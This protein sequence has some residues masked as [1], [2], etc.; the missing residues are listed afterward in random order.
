MNKLLHYG[1][2]LIFIL[3]GIA[4]Y[5]QQPTIEWAQRFNSIDTVSS[6]DKAV[7]IATDAQGNVYITGNS[8]GREPERIITLK[9]SPA[10]Q[11]IWSATYQAD[12]A[13]LAHDIAIDNLGGVYVLGATSG[14][15][16]DF[17]TIRYDALTGQRSWVQQF[18]GTS[19]RNDQPVAIATD[20]S[21]GV[22]VTGTSESNETE[23]NIATIRYDALTGDETWVSQYSGPGYGS[24]GAG[25]ATDNNGNVY[26]IGTS[27]NADG[28]SR[29]MVT[30][31]YEVATGSEKWAIRYSNK[32]RENGDLAYGR[33]IA[34]D[35]NGIV[36]ITGSSYGTDAG[37]NYVTISYDAAG[38]ERWLSR[39]NY[40]P[41]VYSTDEVSAITVDN[42]G[43]VYVTGTSGQNMTTV[44]YDA[45][46]GSEK[47]AMPYENPNSFSS[48]A[49]AITAD[50]MGGVY[51][52]GTSS[53]DIITVRYNSF[54]GKLEWEQIF[55][56]SQQPNSDEAVD[57]A[58]DN[59]GKLYVTSNTVE[60][61]G[62]DKSDIVTIAY[63]A[64]TGQPLWTQTYDRLSS[65]PTNDRPVAVAIDA[66]GNSYVTGTS[67]GEQTSSLVIIKY[68]PAG[69]SLW[70]MEYSSG[71]TVATAVAVDNQGS[72]YVSG[73]RTID[74]W[75][76][77]PD[78][79]TIR[80]NAETGQEVWSSRYRIEEEDY[81]DDR[82]AGLALDKAGN[83]YV[84]GTT[85]AD[86]VVIR[87]EA[88][89]GDTLWVSRFDAG[90]EG[91]NE[92]KAVAI[93]TDP[94]GAVYVT[95][96]TTNYS[97]D[98]GP[99]FI[100][101][102]F[103]ASDG[104]QTWASRYD[105][106]EGYRQEEAVDITADGQGGVYITGMSNGDYLTIRYDATTG[107][108]SWAERYSV[109][110]IGY[111]QPRA[112]AADGKGGVFVTGFG[113]NSSTFYDFATVR[114]DAAT[115]KL[116]WAQTYNYTGGNGDLATA[117]TVDS[118]GGVYVTGY[119]QVD[120][121]GSVYSTV[122]YNGSSGDQV[123]AV[124]TEGPFDSPTDLAIDPQG[125]VIVT[126][127]SMT[128]SADF[129]TIK[130]SQPSVCPELPEVSIT[131]P[132]VARAGTSGSIYTLSATGAT[133]F[134]WQITDSEGRDFTAFSG[135]GTE[136]ISVNWTKKPDVYKVTVSYG[137]TSNCP[138]LTAIRYVHVSDPV[139]GYV[140]GG[141][142]SHAAANPAY[143]FMHRDSRAYWGFVAKY[144]QAGRLQ[145]QTHLILES[146]N[147]YFR[148]T[149]LEDGSLVIMDNRAYVRGY[150][151]LTRLSTTGN[152]ENDPRRFGFLIAA[153]DVQ[154]GAT[155]VSWN[156][157]EKDRLR[158]LIWEINAD[159]TRGTVVY[160]NQATC[161]A[162]LDEHLQA[163]QSIAGGNIIIHGSQLM[164]EQD[165]ALLAAETDQQLIA[166]PTAFQQQ[167]T[168]AFTP[169]QQTAYSLDLYDLKGGLVRQIA[170]GDAENGRRY[171]HE[172]QATGLPKGLYFVRLT[173]DQGVN[174]VKIVV[175]H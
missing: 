132:G 158:I 18:N 43:G 59:Q 86:I 171:E 35:S 41:G 122:K 165:N 32:D 142:W 162:N 94:E 25:I 16:S 123:W 149:S 13:V 85:G 34:I 102:R 27:S 23:A 19:N 45:L 92:E 29:D 11:L 69:D 5:A 62:D 47:W 12:E 112:I 71:Y 95:G 61:G 1:L 46:T 107:E 56:S 137:T 96:N 113:Y 157:R 73:T 150:G 49:K 155:F 136:T 3:C 135:Q 129:L 84:A 167:T 120:Q 31:R 117:I 75:G 8:H 17:I 114:Y 124:Q 175:Q 68:S 30:I 134:L 110:E 80:Y 130:Y 116:D 98:S 90:L 67:E 55:N 53:E 63:E 37:V 168:I 139:A 38:T 83:V 65:L 109:E 138:T 154:Y 77:D 127:S 72:V 143:E 108:Q 87:Y 24:S 14:L 161:D 60:L 140:T 159:G 79:I 78:F 152:L 36:Y 28:F 54:D 89:T 82:A 2:A 106:G 147:I 4:T 50:N 33:S 163:C 160:D 88:A 173:T 15:N 26:V 7:A 66:D 97:S 131:G 121:M 44:G 141:G 105:S 101:I 6:N 128:T 125:N 166:Y 9:F 99:D 144:N 169:V 10:G 93:T 21:G 115:G 151:K 64:G 39:Y 81:S 42:Q 126:G 119:S 146:S 133:S 57:L 103:E 172:V 145:G 174:T 148:S 48:S 76:A 104:S 153:T 164:S 170:T 52:T 111:D 156:S 74:Q 20:N 51:V 91:F 22:Y 70:A 118:V 100:T 40:E 58:L